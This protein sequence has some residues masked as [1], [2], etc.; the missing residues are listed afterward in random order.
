MVGYQ[1]ICHVWTHRFVAYAPKLC[2][3]LSQSLRDLTLT[4]AQFNTRI[5]TH[6]FSSRT[7]SV[8][9]EAVRV[10]RYQFS[11]IHTYIDKKFFRSVTVHT[12]HPRSYPRQLR[13]A[14]SRWCTVVWWHLLPPMEQCFDVRLYVLLQHRSLGSEW[15]TRYL[16]VVLTS[17]NNRPISTLRYS[18]RH[19]V[20]QLT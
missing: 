12:L 20:E 2:N 15:K 17:I 5:K 13:Y 16:K 7:R 6:L 11:F 14:F 9:A 1:N 19:V 3:S 18:H 10:V 4:L 8:T